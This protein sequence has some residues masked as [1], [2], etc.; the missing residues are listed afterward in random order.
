MKYFHFPLVALLLII[1]VGCS[2]G[3]VVAVDEASETPSTSSR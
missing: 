3:N 2:D 1:L